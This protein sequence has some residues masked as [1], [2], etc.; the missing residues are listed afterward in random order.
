M[1]LLG[2]ADNDGKAAWQTFKN[3]W[4]VVSLATIMT[5]LEAMLDY[6]P[7]GGRSRLSPALPTTTGPFQILR[8]SRLAS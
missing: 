8:L 5:G 2:V 1:I 3:R 4:G 6:S 7:K